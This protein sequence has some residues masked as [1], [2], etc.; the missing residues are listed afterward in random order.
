MK[1]MLMAL[2]VLVF[3]ATQSF[4]E[5]IENFC[6]QPEMILEW[7]ELNKKYPHDLNIQALHAMRIGLCEKI[8]RGDLAVAD[9]IAI[10]EA[11]RAAVLDRAFQRQLDSVGEKQTL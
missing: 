2:A 9:G 5:E 8:D 10:F 11:L 3:V 6:H 4:A 1:K 7:E